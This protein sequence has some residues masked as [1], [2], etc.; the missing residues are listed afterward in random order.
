MM[1]MIL[2]IDVSGYEDGKNPIRAAI[3]YYRLDKSILAYLIIYYA[4]A[5]PII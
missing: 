2:K 3:F 5:N 1:I 4:N